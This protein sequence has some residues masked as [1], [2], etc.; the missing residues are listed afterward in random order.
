MP[1]FD[2]KRWRVTPHYVTVEASTE[3]EAIA[4]AE[5]IFQNGGSTS[6]D[7]QSRWM[8]TVDVVPVD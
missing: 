6:I 5:P 7:F 2:V 1:T 8:D 3:E 4:K